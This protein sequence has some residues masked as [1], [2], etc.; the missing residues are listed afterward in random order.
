MSDSLQLHE[1]S[2]TS[3]SSGTNTNQSEDEYTRTRHNTTN[4]Y[5]KDILEITQNIENVYELIFSDLDELF[6]QLF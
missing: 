6:Y 2:D 3:V 5:G 1:L 4:I